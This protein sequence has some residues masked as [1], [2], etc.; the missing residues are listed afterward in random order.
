MARR[1]GRHL[2]PPLGRHRAADKKHEHRRAAWTALT[3]VAAVVATV[4][5]VS[6]GLFAPTS[7]IAG[8]G[9]QTCCSA[10]TFVT[11]FLKPTTIATVRVPGPTTRIWKK[12]PST[13]PTPTPSPTPSPTVPVPPPTTV[14]VSPSPTGPSPTPGPVGGPLFGAFPGFD[15]ATD[16]SE[17]QSSRLDRVTREFGGHLGVVRVYQE[18]NLTLPKMTGPAVV[19]WNFPLAGTLAGQYDAK[20]DAIARGATYPLWFVPWHEVEHNKLAP[21]DYVKLFRYIANRVHAIGNPLVQMTPIFMGWTVRKMDLSTFNAYYPGDAWVDAIG[22][23]TYLSPNVP[24][25]STPE[26]MLSAPIKVAA[27]HHKPLVIGEV[28]IRP[29]YTDAQWSDDVARIIHILDTPA[30]AAVT[31]FETAKYD[32]DWRMSPHPNA[33]AEW[34]KVT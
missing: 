30:T 21:A 24:D 16:H 11:R 2:D 29:G 14:P 27:Q 9:G 34:S 25:L 31:W 26:G 7:A 33:V 32:G 6:S 23:D 8:A 28:S 17:P 3:G 13:S 22:F 10:T 1:T 19:S 20:I 5:A 12:R 18:G 4:L 15:S